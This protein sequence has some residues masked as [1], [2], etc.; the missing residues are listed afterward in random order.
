VPYTIKWLEM[1][2]SVLPAFAREIDTGDYTKPQSSVNL[3]LAGAAHDE[4]L[5]KE[6]NL[7]VSWQ[8]PLHE[9]LVRAV[10]AGHGDHSISALTEV[11]KKPTGGQVVS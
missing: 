7:D 4:E 11:L 9:L 2:G 6:A 3:F 5:G 10:A 8:R 1:I